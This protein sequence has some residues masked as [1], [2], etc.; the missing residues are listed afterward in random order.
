[1][2]LRAE[3]LFRQ[4]DALQPL[5]QQSRRELVAEGRKHPASGFLEQIPCV[6]PIRVSG[7]YRFTGGQLE[8]S[9]KLSSVRERIP[10]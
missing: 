6:G 9:K 4:L 8:R 5:R 3:L 1:V 2:R 10:R 7:E